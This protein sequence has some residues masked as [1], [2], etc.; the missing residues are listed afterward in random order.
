MKN[1]LKSY[2]G[3]HKGEECY[4][5]GDGISLKY[6]DLS[7]LKDKILIGLNNS[8]FHNQINHTN[9]KYFIEIEPYYFYP[10]FDIARYFLNTHPLM[11]N[12]WNP[13]ARLYKK[14]IKE[15]KYIHFLSKKN[16]FAFSNRENIIFLDQKSLNK[17][18][19]QELD[20]KNLETMK[21]SL[22]TAISLAIYMGFEKI[23]LLGC[24]YLTTP[25][26]SRHW[27]EKGKG[28]IG[29]ELHDNYFFSFYNDVKKY[30]DINLIT[31]NKRHSRIKHLNYYEFFKVKEEFKENHLLM[32]KKYLD[33][34]RQV[35][36]YNI[37]E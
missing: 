7:I 2:K 1:N 22:K 32:E 36:Y 31:V 25:S 20:V 8:I 27:Y 19:Y 14:K 34:F 4:I 17:E 6:M 26:L 18:V 13:V 24:D 29:P 5:L 23:Y 16:Q 35:K 3:I 37:D 15:N 33:R 11:I 10:F 9:A 28:I 12:I 21:G 30:I